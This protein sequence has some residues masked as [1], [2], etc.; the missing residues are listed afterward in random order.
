[1]GTLF[2]LVTGG[3]AVA[4]FNDELNVK[5]RASRLRN[6]LALADHY[7]KFPIMRSSMRTCRSMTGIFAFDLP[8]QFT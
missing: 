1:M 3:S 2:A 7:V 6:W 5:F 8:V 4:Q